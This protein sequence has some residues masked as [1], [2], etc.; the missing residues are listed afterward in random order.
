M[1]HYILWLNVFC[2]PDKYSKLKLTVCIKD[3]KM[4]LETEKHED[5]SIDIFR[6]NYESF[7]QYKNMKVSDVSSHCSINTFHKVILWSHTCK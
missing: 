6:G 7:H 2:F 1:T 4:K 3:K 5:M